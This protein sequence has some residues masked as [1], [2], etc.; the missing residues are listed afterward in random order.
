MTV[1]PADQVQD[2]VEK[3]DPYNKPPS[4]WD[5]EPQCFYLSYIS[6][7]GFRRYFH[8]HH[9]PL[10]R[11]KLE[12]IVK[13]MVRN[14]DKYNMPPTVP[15]DEPW[16]RKSYIVLVAEREG[17]DLR[18]GKIL[19]QYKAGQNENHTFFNAWHWTL[20]IS[21]T[22]ENRSVM[23]CINHMRN[24]NG[25]TLG[26]GECEEFQVLYPKRLPGGRVKIHVLED[27]NT[28]LGPPAPPPP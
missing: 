26:D 2:Y 25:A 7:G 14:I 19:I 12:E 22:K 1:V 28:N 10:T 5:T 13:R 27:G 20:D 8:D 3:R 15:E 6:A 18:R 9:K 24:E 21:S 23:A 17:L 11:N 16:T 4:H